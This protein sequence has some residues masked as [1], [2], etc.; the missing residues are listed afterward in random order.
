MIMLLNRKQIQTYSYVFY[1]VDKFL[2]LISGFVG[3]V[4]S[5][6]P[7]RNWQISRAVASWAQLLGTVTCCM[8]TPASAM[9][10]LYFWG[11]V[12]FLDICCHFGMSDSNSLNRAFLTVAVPSNL[13]GKECPQFDSL[14]S[15]GAWIRIKL[16]LLPKTVCCCPQYVCMNPVAIN[17]EHLVL[18]IFSQQPCNRREMLSYSC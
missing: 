3:W 9:V 4:L 13:S 10:H 16:K 17:F 5:D 7:K 18:Y 15:S 6:F 8:P 1:T 14:L 2:N 11:V 12:L